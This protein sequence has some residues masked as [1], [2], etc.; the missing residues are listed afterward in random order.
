MAETYSACSEGIWSYF[1]RR[2]HARNRATSSQ[3]H[4]TKIALQSKRFPFQTS[5]IISAVMEDNATEE[6]SSS[7]DSGG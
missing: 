6:E 2:S 4:T 3:Q 5:I 1:W 7:Q